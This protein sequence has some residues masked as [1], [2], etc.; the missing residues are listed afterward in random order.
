[1]AQAAEVPVEAAAN[2]RIHR[3]DGI[4]FCHDDKVERRKRELAK[5]LPG[6]AAEAVP[7]DGSRGNP[8]RDRKSES[9]CRSFIEL[10]KNGKETIGRSVSAAEDTGIVRAC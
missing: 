8:T 5:R 4:A 7:V 1:L 9:C 6:Q 2:V 3:F 10:R